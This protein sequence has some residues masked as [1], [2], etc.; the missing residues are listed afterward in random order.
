MPAASAGH[1]N[2]V[3]STL[4]VHVIHPHSRLPSHEPEMHEFTRP[5]QYFYFTVFRAGHLPRRMPYPRTRAACR[6]ERSEPGRARMGAPARVLVPL[7]GGVDSTVI[8]A[9]AH[10]C[11]PPEEPV[12]LVNVCFAEGASPDRVAALDALRELRRVA[13]GR[14]WRLI[15]VDSTLDEVD[16]HHDQCAPS[17]PIIAA[18]H[19]AV[20]R[21]MRQPR[22]CAGPRIAEIQSSSGKKVSFGVHRVMTQH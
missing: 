13:P 19:R 16:T 2:T 21:D 4:A 22:R 12:D 9:L 11:L 14:E 18:P 10:A 3:R 6:Y 7:S 5:L 8:A 20:S 15:T 1:L 17:P